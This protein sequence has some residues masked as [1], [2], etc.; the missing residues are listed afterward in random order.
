MYDARACYTRRAPRGLF[1]T[2][3]LF[4]P[5]LAPFVFNI[6]DRR[7]RERGEIVFAFAY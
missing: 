7:E 4:E 6:R 5:V 2:L 3:G 1:L